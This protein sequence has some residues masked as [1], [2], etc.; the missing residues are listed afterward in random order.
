MHVHYDTYCESCSV[1]KTGVVSSCLL[2][3]CVMDEIHVKEFFVEGRGLFHDSL[4]E[5]HSVFSTVPSLLSRALL[6]M[7]YL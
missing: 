2:S 6:K 3:S 4:S 7:I 1:G 5:L